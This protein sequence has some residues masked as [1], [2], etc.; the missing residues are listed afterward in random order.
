G[1]RDCGG[2]PSVR[3]ALRGKAWWAGWDRTGRYAKLNPPRNYI[4]KAYRRSALSAFADCRVKQ[5]RSPSH[6]AS[7]PPQPASRASRAGLLQIWRAV[8][9][10]NALS[11]Q[12][13]GDAGYEQHD[14][15]SGA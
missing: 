6:A 12:A 1:R 9:L 15:K 3:F 5:P 11:V 4:A 13:V 14:G 2:P 8:A 10:S 7:E